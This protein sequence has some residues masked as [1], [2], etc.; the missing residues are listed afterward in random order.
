MCHLKLFKI[1]NNHAFFNYNCLEMF[2]IISETACW[3]WVRM[4]STRNC[5]ILKD[6]MTLLLK[7]NGSSADITACPS[8]FGDSNHQNASLSG[9]SRFAAEE[10]KN[11]DFA[12]N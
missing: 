11:D 4:F 8:R 5:H 6:L 12:V 7:V 1:F 2:F 9:E 10:S 3:D